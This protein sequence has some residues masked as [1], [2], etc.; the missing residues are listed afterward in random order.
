MI[1][2]YQ[3]KVLCSIKYLLDWLKTKIKY[4]LFGLK[5]KFSTK[6]LFLP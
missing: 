3:I 2:T 1:P 4:L 5:A 6:I